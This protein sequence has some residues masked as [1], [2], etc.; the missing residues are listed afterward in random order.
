SYVDRTSDVQTAALVATR[1]AVVYPNSWREER[2][3]VARWAEE[4]RDVLDRWQ[5]WY[6]S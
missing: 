3:A 5:F 6:N 2:M 1:A 4:Y